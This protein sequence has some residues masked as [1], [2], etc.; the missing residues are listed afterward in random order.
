[1][2]NSNIKRYKVDSFI[3]G[4]LT[5]ENYRKAVVH[6]TLTI[7]YIIPPKKNIANHYKRHPQDSRIHQLFYIHATIL[8]LRNTNIFEYAIASA[9]CEIYE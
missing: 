5:Q 1:M 3:V 9:Y 6:S 2:Y 7:K 4:Q 8:L